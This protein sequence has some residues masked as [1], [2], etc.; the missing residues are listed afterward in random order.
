MMY[1]VFENFR[2][3]CLKIY[4]LD[5]AKFLSAPW[6][7]WLAVLKK[8]KVKLDLL[9]DINMLLIIEKRIKRG[10]CCH[11]HRYGKGNNK[12]NKKYEKNKELSYLQ[13]WNVN[14]LYVSIK[15][16]IK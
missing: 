16:S 14:N 12:Y 11:L 3:M 8:T 7:P 6:W 15:A 13:Y 1:D 10:I 9:T 2:N 4:K 5:S